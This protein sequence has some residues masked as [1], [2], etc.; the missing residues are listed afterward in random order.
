MFREPRTVILGRAIAARGLIKY[1]FCRW[2]AAL[3]SL[4]KT[5]RCQLDFQ[6]LLII[7][8][9]ALASMKRK[10]T[11]GFLS[12]RVGRENVAGMGEMERSPRYGLWSSFVGESC[13]ILA[14]ISDQSWWGKR[15]AKSCPSTPPDRPPV[16]R[17]V[18]GS[19][20]VMQLS[21]APWFPSAKTYPILWFFG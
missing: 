5:R 17:T 19:G 3:R 21:A 18:F 8:T 1:G 15:M 16:S 4:L 20:R 13:E 9:R 7:L 10:M 6:R 14:G 11:R 2:S 12:T